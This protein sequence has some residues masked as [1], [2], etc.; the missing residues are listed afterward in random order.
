[1]NWIS[2]A[3]EW[4]CMPAAALHIAAEV[5]AAAPRAGDCSAGKAL[6]AVHS[7]NGHRNMSLSALDVRGGIHV[8]THRHVVATRPAWRSLCCEDKTELE[9]SPRRGPLLHVAGQ[10][11]HVKAW[12]G[13][14]DMHMQGVPKSPMSA[15]C[16]SYLPPGSPVL[17]CAF[18]L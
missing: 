13:L 1:M 14:V 2:K 9:R 12:R 6:G 16:I 15:I 7:C 5:A 18:S 8:L 17:A 11:N 10:H 4:D 3:Q